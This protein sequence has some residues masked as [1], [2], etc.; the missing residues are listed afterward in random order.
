[1][2]WITLL[3]DPNA[4]VVLNSVTPSVSGAT[5]GNDISATLFLNGNAPAGGANV[6]RSSSNAAAA[7]GPA[8]VTVPPGQGFQGFTITTS[9]VTADTP[10]TITGT[11]GIS[12]T[13][14]ITVLAGASNTGLRRPT[15][16]AADAG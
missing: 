2:A 9:P 16:N 11:Y 7:Q 12:Q 15:A 4:P 1:T 5:G 3:A 8:S 13:A 6:T 14:T 10:V